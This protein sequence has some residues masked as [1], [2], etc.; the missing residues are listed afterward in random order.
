MCVSSRNGVVGLL[1]AVWFFLGALGVQAAA[2]KLTWTLDY[3]RGGE[4]WVIG[5]PQTVL[6]GGKVPAT[7]V[8]IEITT[9]GTT[10]CRWARSRP[11]R[12]CPRT[13]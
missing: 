2:T 1:A 3:P 7:S 13:P 8:T 5:Q 11:S 10:F 12:A 6:I 4:V 9:N